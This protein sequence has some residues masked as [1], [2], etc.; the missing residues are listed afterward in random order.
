MEKEIMTLPVHLGII[1][2]GNGRWAKK[3]GMPRTFG[4]KAG[5]EAMRKI[6]RECREIG[7]K[8]VTCY[9]FSTENWKRPKEEVDVLMRLFDEYLDEAQERFDKSRLVFIGDKSLFS[10]SLREKMIR[11]EKETADIEGFT[12]FLA[13]NY[14]GRDEVVRA[15]RILAE[16]AAAGEIS[17][18]DIDE[19]AIER[20]LYTYPAPDC[21]YIIRTSGEQRLSNFLMW[22]GTY[23][24]LYFTDTLWPDF[25]KKELY[26]ALE[27]YSRRQRRF[28]GI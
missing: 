19:D 2:D 1:M 14:G 13:M 15:A 18:A 26:L 21:D 3:R 11:L 23:S 8:Y 9:A 27:E 6:L 5:A 7:I 17:P 22:Q 4:H 20:E 16:K 28:G 10:S 12:I 24:E 25:D